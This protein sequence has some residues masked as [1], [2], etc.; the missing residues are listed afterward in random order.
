[1]TR[2]IIEVPFPRASVKPLINYF[3]IVL[4]QK[5]K[6]SANA[7]AHKKRRKEMS[8][9]ARS[10]RFARLQVRQREREK[11]KNKKAIIPSSGLSPTHTHIQKKKGVVKKKSARA[12]GTLTFLI[13]HISMFSSW[14]SPMDAIFSFL[15]CLCY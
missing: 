12:Q 5:R 7:R 13:F 11:N 9:D 8:E 2:E 4:S 1:M 15:S 6:R 14:S 3:I 10:L